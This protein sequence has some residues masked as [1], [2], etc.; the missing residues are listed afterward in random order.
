MMADTAAAT[1]AA[2]SAPA[3]NS[4]VALTGA[5]SP[6]GT[7]RLRPARCLPSRRSFCHLRANGPHRERIPAP[8]HKYNMT[9]P[10][11]SPKVQSVVA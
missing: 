5:G 6:L 2:S 3:E 4:L 1:T 11:E 9:S 10:H 7:V 8:P